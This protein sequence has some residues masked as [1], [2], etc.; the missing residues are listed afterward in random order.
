MKV[1]L[2]DDDPG[3]AHVASLALHRVGGFDV[4]VTDQA[5]EALKVATTG[6]LS[7]VI[8]DVMMPRVDGPTLFRRLRDL[9]NCRELP[10]IFLTAKVQTHEVERLMSLGAAG[11]ISKP[12]DPMTLSI[13]VEEILG[14]SSASYDGPALPLSEL[15]AKRS[16]DVRRDLGLLRLAVSASRPEAGDLA[17]KLTGV[18]GTFGF[19]AAGTIAS[20][21]EQRL[22]ESR[23][24][25]SAERSD[26]LLSLVDE[27]EHLLF[28]RTT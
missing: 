11:V 27:V 9:P 24:E 6:D 4:Q 8:L 18:C 26:E 12:F 22:S 20:R 5:D 1:L 25:R 21:L 2:V 28:A 14:R 7:C 3:I 23:N 10:I 19:S 16:D 17:H 15:W 13:Q